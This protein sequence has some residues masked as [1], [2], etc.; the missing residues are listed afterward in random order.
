MKAAAEAVSIRE[1]SMKLVTR[2]LACQ[3]KGARCS[4]VRERVRLRGIT[5]RARM[6]PVGPGLRRGPRQGRWWAYVIRPD[7][8]ATNVEAVALPVEVEGGVHLCGHEVLEA[9]GAQ[10]KGESHVH[11]QV[12]DPELLEE[13]PAADRRGARARVGEA[14]LALTQDRRCLVGLHEPEVV[15]EGQV[16]RWVD[17]QLG[18][19]PDD[20]LVAD[21]VLRVHG[22]AV[23]QLQVGDDGLDRATV[24]LNGG[25]DG[26][27]RGVLDIGAMAGDRHVGRHG[28][29]RALGG[30]YAGRRRLGSGDRAAVTPGGSA[31]AAANAVGGESGSVGRSLDLEHLLLEWRRRASRGARGELAATD[32]ELVG[33]Y[34]LAKAKGLARGIAS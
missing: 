14:S 13:L 11:T 4:K 17:S 23:P 28:A 18:L 32:V 33:H 1:H 16:R 24:A 34:L 25:D 26:P 8:A 10:D 29:A 5:R 21:D 31:K 2:E 7:D 22:T 30:A 12:V 9:W 19:L 6:G 20:K 27:S 15:A 3:T